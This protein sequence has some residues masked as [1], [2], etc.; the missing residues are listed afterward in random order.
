MLL[1]LLARGADD[2]LD[3]VVVDQAGNVRVGDLG[4]WLTAY[5]RNRQHKTKETEMEKTHM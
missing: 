1:E 4:H 3:L 2:G 5:V